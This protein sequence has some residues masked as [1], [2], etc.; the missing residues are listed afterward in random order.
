MCVFLLVS[1]FSWFKFT[2]A[3]SSSDSSK[4]S[5]IGFLGTLGLFLFGASFTYTIFYII[6]YHFY[7]FKKKQ[8]CLILWFF[9]LYTGYLSSLEALFSI[10]S[11]ASK[12]IL[13]S[14]LFIIHICASGLGRLGFALYYRV[15][16]F[17]SSAPR[18]L[19]MWWL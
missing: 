16:G 19:W 4:S 3:G 18:A 2:V 14:W 9:L 12:K 1:V 5:G 10:K 11:I 7:I 8:H 17:P 13:I 15:F 6:Y